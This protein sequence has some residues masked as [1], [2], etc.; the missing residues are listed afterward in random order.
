MSGAAAVAA[1]SAAA[2]R[3][4]MLEEEE[5]MTSYPKT[6]MEN[7]FEY[8]IVRSNTEA[9]RKPEEFRKLLDEESRAGWVMVEKFDNARV[10]F[11]RPVSA[12]ENDCF[13]APEIDPYRVHF[14]ASQAL[15]VLIVF[16]LLFGLLLVLILTA[17]L[18]KH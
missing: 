6:E 12:R 2:A 3:R 7:D 8:K 15:L 4:R 10:R 11:K 1:A 14:G 9:F 16:G 17:V 18:L 13:L 5:E